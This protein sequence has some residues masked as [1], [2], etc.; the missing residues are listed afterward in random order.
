MKA[1]SRQE[2][3]GLWAEIDPKTVGEA[4]PFREYCELVNKVKS[5]WMKD[6]P[7]MSPASASNQ[8]YV[9]HLEDVLERGGTIG[10]DELSGVSP[11][12]LRFDAWCFPN[13]LNALGW[14]KEGVREATQCSS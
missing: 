12:E 14:T 3:N 7:E 6:I 4:V 13:L 5:R 1:L 11:R 9:A 2:W 8:R 10:A